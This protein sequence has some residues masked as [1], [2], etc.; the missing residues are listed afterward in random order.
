M[1]IHIKVT[2]NSKKESVIEIDKD[3]FD[4]SVKEPAE[5]NRANDRVIEIIREKF[6]DAKQI[7]IVSGH[8]SPSKLLSVN[9]D[10]Q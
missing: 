4:I 2:T 7:K 10:D 6:P 3:H 1:Y 5:R 8:H 9:L